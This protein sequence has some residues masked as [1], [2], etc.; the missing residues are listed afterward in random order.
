MKLSINWL[1]KFVSLDEVTP[2]EVA[3]K[4]TMGA[5]EVEEIQKV[6]PKLHGPLVVGKIL[7]VQK[8]PNADRLLVTKVTTDGKNQL[9]IVCGAKNIK[10]GQLVPVALPGA[11]VVNRQDGSELAIKTTVIREIESSGMLC[12]PG[13]LG[14]STGDPGGI[15]ILDAKATV[16]KNVIDYLSLHRD[17]I[18]EVASRSNRG[19]ALSVFG[20][21]KEISALTKKNL[22]ELVFSSQTPKI[23][24]SVQNILSKIE[25]TNDTYIFY[26]VTIEDI[27][28]SESPEWLKKLLES[29]G[30]KPI[31]N[32]VDITNYINFTFGQPLHAYD[33]A[34]LKGSFL[35][36]RSLKKSEKITTID[37][38]TRELKEGVLVIADEL[39]PQAIAGIMGSKD[40]EVSESTQA[41]VLEAAV[42]SPQK[43]R[44]ASRAVGLTSE[45]SKRFERGVDSNFTHKVLLYTIGLIESFA[46]LPN[47][48]PRI[49]TI[50]QAGNP[51]AKENKI[52]FSKDEVT[53]VLGINLKSKEITNLLESLEFKTNQLQND[54][55]EVT[56]PTSR[57]TDVTRPIDL[58][59]EVARLHG[60]DRIPF[61]APK[62]TSSASKL[63]TSLELVK[64]HFLACG[65]SES[66]LSSLIGEQILNNKEFTFDKSKAIEMLNPLSNEH[67]VLRQHLIPGLLEALK[68]NQSHQVTQVKLFEIGKVYFSTTK[69]SEKETGVTEIL[70][71]AGLVNGFDEAWYLNQKTINITELLFFSAKGVLES[72][73]TNSNCKYTFYKSDTGFLHPSY[74]MK[75]SVNNKEIGVFGS[76]HPKIEKRFEL[77][78]PVIVFEFS[79][80]T[81]L[82]NLE[83]IRTYQ[84]ISSKPLVLRDI[85]IDLP[86]KYE[87]SLVSSEINK[88]KS[89]FVIGINLISV[90]ELDKENRS[91]TYRLKMQDLEQTLTA[92]QIE[93]EV[94]RV[95]NH[96]SSC[97]N[98]KFRV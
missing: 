90:Y 50:N 30:I 45:A 96:L 58:V 65:F 22:K 21:S 97:F 20:L 42:F 34:K 26:T 3:Q 23:D 44:R 13:E 61:E 91:L 6:G 27:T 81:L 36:S 78:G 66:Y 7:E 92:N 38:K 98:A 79:L 75:I 56:V 57:I 76:L 40:S 95:K 94:K 8:H 28:I 53:R 4:L 80:E 11:V 59:E 25:N 63:K 60:Y 73:F 71:L 17:T 14:I 15:L 47:K 64:H 52:I 93:D 9:Q 54:K 70:T 41:I 72:L 12:S 48:K 88:V 68:L 32:I 67:S 1:N 29:V 31:N 10:V 39:K 33:K 19:D 24:K 82:E 49:G 62:S 18:L 51:K 16:G 37:G 84:K 2:E 86:K 83:K 35:I 43:V 74:Q 5:F 85:T 87:A 46:R 55:I 89:T 77:I 69:P